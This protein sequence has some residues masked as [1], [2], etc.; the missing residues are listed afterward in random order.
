M[1][2]DALKHIDYS[3]VRFVIM[4]DGPRMKEFLEESTGLNV[5]FLG[6]LSYEKMCG[7]LASCDIVVNPIVKESVASIINK[8]ADYAASGKPV[9]NTQRSSEYRALISRYK[10]GFN[11][12]KCADIASYINTLASDPALRGR[13]GVGARKCAEEL[14]DRNTSYK[15][16][17]DIILA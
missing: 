10:M 2:F 8:H 14:F 11:A 1:V 9:I 15:I 17:E 4:G 5:L 16:I 3:T 12:E 7:V 6:R 13:M